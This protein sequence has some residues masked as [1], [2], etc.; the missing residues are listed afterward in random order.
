VERITLNGGPAGQAGWR[1]VLPNKKHEFSAGWR[2]VQGMAGW[3]PA[4][5]DRPVVGCT[6]SWPTEKG[7]P[8]GYPFLQ[9]ALPFSATRQTAFLCIPPARPSVFSAAC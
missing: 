7:W 6:L 5:Q 9:P 3:Q 2:A 1:A 4:Q 8:E